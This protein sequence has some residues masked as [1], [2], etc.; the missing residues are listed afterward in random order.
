MAAQRHAPVQYGPILMLAANRC[1]L[2]FQ[3][4]KQPALYGRNTSTRRSQRYPHQRQ[5]A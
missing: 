5:I 2:L 1:R 3:F 4:Q